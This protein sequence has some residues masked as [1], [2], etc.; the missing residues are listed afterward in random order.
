MAFTY[1]GKHE[2]TP[3][4]GGQTFTHTI[5]DLNI[6]TPT[7]GLLVLKL[8]YYASANNATMD[9]QWNGIDM[10]RAAWF[11]A[12]A[13]ARSA[14]I[15]YLTN[16][17]TG[18]NDLTIDFAV[19]SG[20]SVLAGWASVSWYEG[21]HQTQGSVLDDAGTATGDADPTIELNPTEDNTLCVSTYYSETNNELTAGNSQTL[22]D[23]IDQGTRCAGAGY[24]IQTTAAAQ[25]LSWAGADNLWV[26]AAA[27]FFVPAGAPEADLPF[28][29]SRH[30]MTLRGN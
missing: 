12:G 21:A 30:L 25:T 17:A 2:E 29:A 24:I 9:A 1:A 10:G 3:V 26:E 5:S 13:S 28:Y 27:N 23:E 8:V 15:F 16:P 14:V 6:G 11:D 19:E 18:T 22:L 4:T 7:D 20:G